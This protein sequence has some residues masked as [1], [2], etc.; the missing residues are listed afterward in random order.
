MLEHV[1]PQF[2]VAVHPSETL[3]LAPLSQVILAAGAFRVTAVGGSTGSLHRRNVLDADV[4]VFPCAP[5]AIT[6]H[7]NVFGLVVVNV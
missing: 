3:T 6:Y 2:V 5:T 1:P 7:V 4:A